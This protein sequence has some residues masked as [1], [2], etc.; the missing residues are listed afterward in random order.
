MDF[1]VSVDMAVLKWLNGFAGEWGGFD[2]FVYTVA[3]AHLL[4]GAWFI[5]L[6]WWIWFDEK[7]ASRIPDETTRH[8]FVIRSIATALFAIAL[9]RVLQWWLPPRQSPMSDVALGLVHPLG[10]PTEFVINSFPSDHAILFFALATA[11]WLW[12]RPI[13]AAAYLWTVVVICLPRLYIGRHFPS[14]I[15][16]G[17]LIG[18]T[19]MVLAHRLR[20]LERTI[21]VTIRWE[22]RQRASFYLVAFLATYEMANLFDGVRMVGGR[23]LGLIGLSGF[24]NF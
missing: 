20:L 16:A 10:I 3:R 23:V 9:G 22:H 11:V 13:G 12:S 2:L 5:G 14:D 18:I 4:K 8:A 21:D 19:L 24:G 6:F 7:E 1:I 15:V 17:A